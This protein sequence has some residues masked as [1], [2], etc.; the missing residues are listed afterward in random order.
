MQG[1]GYSPSGGS[2]PSSPLTLEPGLCPDLPALCCSGGVYLPFLTL[3]LQPLKPQDSTQN[4]PDLHLKPSDSRT[5]WRLIDECMYREAP[6]A[7]PSGDPTGSSISG[8]SPT[9]LRHWSTPQPCRARWKLADQPLIGSSL[10]EGFTP[11]VTTGLRGSY[12]DGKE[13]APFWVSVLF[14]S[15]QIPQPSN[16]GPHCVLRKPLP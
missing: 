14:P 4:P 7:A 2:L 8:A 3:H 5:V 10:P 1:A 9:D 12:R 6:R 11:H 15:Q 16:T 13:A